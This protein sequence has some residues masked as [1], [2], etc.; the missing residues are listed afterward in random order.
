MK[1]KSEYPL[2]VR[3]LSNARGTFKDI[4]ISSQ[5]D[6]MLLHANNKD[7]GK[8]SHSRSLIRTIVFSPLWEE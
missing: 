4:Q 6:P 7:S 2:G 8:P 5:E 1:N 3:R